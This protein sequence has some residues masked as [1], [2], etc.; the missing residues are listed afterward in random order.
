MIHP[1]FAD[2]SKIQILIDGW[3]KGYNDTLSCWNGGWVHLT[4]PSVF[5]KL[6]LPL[7]PPSLLH[8][9]LPRHQCSLIIFQTATSLCVFWER[10]AY[11]EERLSELWIDSVHSVCCHYDTDGKKRG[12][13]APSH[14]LALHDSEMTK[15]NSSAGVVPRMSLLPPWGG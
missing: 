5:D 1:N 11:T 14:P 13:P 7:P 2:K 12:H 4:F 15:L 6:P 8:S 10:P 3:V 9:V